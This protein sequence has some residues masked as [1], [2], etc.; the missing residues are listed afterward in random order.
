MP[1]PFLHRVP[2]LLEAA[3]HWHASLGKL[4][5]HRRLRRAG[6]RG[7]FGSDSLFAGTE[8]AVFAKRP[9][10]HRTNTCLSS[11]VIAL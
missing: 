1:F 5:D 11:Q 4:V 8:E 6:D 10:P 3:V 9:Q 2:P 7:A